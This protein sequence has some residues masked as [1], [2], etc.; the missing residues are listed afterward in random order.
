MLL[1]LLITL[2]WHDALVPGVAD[3]TRDVI[4][5]REVGVALFGTYVL[6]VQLAALLMMAG[7]VGASH[8]RRRELLPEASS[9]SE[10]RP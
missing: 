4:G 10:L 1:A 6:A 7:L 9:P 3:T 2:L 8:L 5:P